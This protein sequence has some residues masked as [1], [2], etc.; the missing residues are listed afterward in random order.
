MTKQ[1]GKAFHEQKQESL[2]A[3]GDI[4]D[5]NEYTTNLQDDS[6]NT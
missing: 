4:S 6:A 1:T 3:N 2:K 5:K